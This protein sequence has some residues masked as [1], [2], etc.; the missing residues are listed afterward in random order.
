M[1]LLADLFVL[2]AIVGV[3]VL[4][5]LVA[6]VGSAWFRERNSAASRRTRAKS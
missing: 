3:A 1:N 4:L 6:V 5:G 2:M